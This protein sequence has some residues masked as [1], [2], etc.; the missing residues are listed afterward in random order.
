[1]GKQEEQ[2]AHGGERLSSY[3]FCLWFCWLQKLLRS[4]GYLRPVMGWGSDRIDFSVWL[5]FCPSCGHHPSSV[6]IISS[7]PCRLHTKA[8]ANFLNWDYDCSALFRSP[9]LCI[10]WFLCLGCSF[11]LHV[12]SLFLPSPWLSCWTISSVR[13][14]NL[15]CLQ[16]LDQSLAY[17][18]C[19][20]RKNLFDNKDLFDKYMD[21]LGNKNFLLCWIPKG[22]FALM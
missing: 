22:Y 1:M 15:L 17:S 16:C 19:L 2:T 12:P 4:Q 5:H 3:R 6:T 20:L 10:C 8:T 13:T 14:D 7:P 9:G 11:P 21:T 18:R